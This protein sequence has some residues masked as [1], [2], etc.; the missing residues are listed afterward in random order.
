M[1]MTDFVF[2]L[3]YIFFSFFFCS[4]FP[5]TFFLWYLPF[6]FRPFP[7]FP[8][9]DRLRAALKSLSFVLFFFHSSCRTI[10]VSN[11][12]LF[13]FARGCWANIANFSSHGRQD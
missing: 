12:P 2:F 10:L 11:F 7:F 5:A 3:F 8:G 4:P 13:V 1:S 9:V 6:A